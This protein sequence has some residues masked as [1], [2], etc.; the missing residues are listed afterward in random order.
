MDYVYKD[1]E[2]ELRELLNITYKMKEEGYRLVQICCTTLKDIYELNYSFAINY[3]FRNYKVKITPEDKVPS[4]S[5]IFHP[6]FLYENEMKDL[7]GLD[8]L[9][10][11]IDY[12]GHLYDLGKKTPYKINIEGGGEENE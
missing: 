4:I 9:Y 3:D 6:A 2:I 5:N 7:F 10:T 8:I 11:D 12:K 1:S